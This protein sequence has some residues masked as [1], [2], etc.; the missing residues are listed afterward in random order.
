MHYATLVTVEI[1]ACDE[2]MDRGQKYHSGNRR[3]KEGK[4]GTPYHIR[5]IPV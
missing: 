5:H 4:S 3:A 2:D 1:E